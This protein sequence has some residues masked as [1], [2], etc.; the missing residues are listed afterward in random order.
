LQELKQHTCCRQAQG[1][2]KHPVLCEGVQCGEHLRDSTQAATCCDSLMTWYI[3]HAED[4]SAIAAIAAKYE[5]TCCRMH[6]SVLQQYNSRRAC[7]PCVALHIVA[8]L[9]T[10]GKPFFASRSST[11]SSM[12]ELH[13]GPVNPISKACRTSSCC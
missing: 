9:T 10:S 5:R 8:L 11:C 6:S 7:T 12:P 3:V 4:S 2:I 1:G 13:A